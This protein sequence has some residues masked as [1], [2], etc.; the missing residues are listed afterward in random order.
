M[1]SLIHSAKHA[2]TTL[3]FTVD[4]EFFFHDYRS[5]CSNNFYGFFE[6]TDYALFV[7]EQDK[8]LVVTLI[9]NKEGDQAKYVNSWEIADELKLKEVFETIAMTVVGGQDARID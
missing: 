5:G 6:N 2:L 8:R 3:C 9:N 1:S 4:C 7:E